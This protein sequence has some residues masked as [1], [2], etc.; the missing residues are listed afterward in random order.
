MQRQMK[1][2][3]NSCDHKAVLDRLAHVHS[4]AS[5][6]WGTM[7]A[8]QMVCHLSD[9]LRAALG[10]KYVSPSGNFFTRTVVK[11]FAL[12]GPF[13]WP[14]GYKTRPEVDQM[15]GGTTPIDFVADVEELHVLL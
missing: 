2:L 13:P 15:Q 10:E 8:H 3:L 11:S 14:H 12:W 9:S 4:K 1:T 5:A 7:S 6:Q